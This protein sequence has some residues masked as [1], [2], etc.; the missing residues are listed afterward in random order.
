MLPSGERKD[1]TQTIRVGSFLESSLKVIEA[2]TYGLDGKLAA[3]SFEIISYN[4]ETK[5]YMVRWY[6]EGNA[7]DLPITPSANGF[8]MEYPAD[9]DRIRFTVTVANGTWTEIA[10]RISPDKAPVRFIE[11][12]LRRLQNTDWPAGG[13][14]PSR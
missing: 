8:S 12:T 6:G 4:P 14:L 11:M 13:S 5:A 10:E 9:K 7:A 3:N 2:R 1:F